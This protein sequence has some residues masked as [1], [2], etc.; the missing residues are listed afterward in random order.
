MFHLIL[1]YLNR[2]KGV[3]ANMLKV[4][5]KRRRI[6]EE[7]KQANEEAGSKVRPNEDNHAELAALRE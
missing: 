7:M 2:S 3:S 1:Y 4:G 6:K 5:S